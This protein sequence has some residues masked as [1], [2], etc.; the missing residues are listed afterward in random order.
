MKKIRIIYSVI[1]LLIV[2]IVA[3]NFA[4]KY[5]KMYCV[6]IDIDVNSGRIRETRYILF[7]KVN[8][9]IF[10]TKMSK[11]V[12]VL[13]I[14]KSKPIW[15]NDTIK[16]TILYKKYPF[17]KWHGA[18]AACESIFKYIPLNKYPESKQREL[19]EICLKHLKEGEINEI[20]QITRDN[21]GK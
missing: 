15:K 17:G 14:N 3:F 20:E 6:Y 5:D 18:I 16:D 13:N 11:K 12:Q 9:N 19:I 4:P 21:F 10:E 1:L 2:F 8:Q 7:I